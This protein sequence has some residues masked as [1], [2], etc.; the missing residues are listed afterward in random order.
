[1]NSLSAALAVILLTA[2]ATR[3]QVVVV[4]WNHTWAVMHPMGTLPNGPGGP[5][6]DFDATW[7]LK[8]ADFAAQYDGPA[9][10]AV[11]SQS[12]IATTLNS[13]DSRLAQGPIGYGAATYFTAAGAEFTAFGTGGTLTTPADGQKRAAYFRSTFTVPAG[14][15]ALIRP[16]IRYLLDDGAY[17]YLDGE[18]V[19]AIFM[20][21][22]TPPNADLYAGTPEVVAGGTG[23]STESALRSLNLDLAA[24]TANA[25]TGARTIKQILSLTE[26][27]H[28]LALSVRNP[29]GLTSSDIAMALE[30][31]GDAGCTLSATTANV[32]R[33]D[34]GTPFVPGDDTFT[35]SATVTGINAGAGWTSDDAAMASGAYDAPVTFGPYPVSGGA[36]VVNFTS[37]SGTPCTAQV[38]VP[39]PG[40]V[41]TATAQSF[42]RHPQGTLDPADDT[43]TTSVLVSGQFVSNGWRL[44]STTP[45][46]AAAGSPVSGTTGTVAV[47]GPYNTA[48]APVTVVLADAADPAI[49]TQIVLAPQ[50]YIGTRTFGGVT[51]NFLSAAPLPTQ[52]TATATIAPVM[53]HTNGGGDIWREFR[54]PVFDL[55][56]T[57]AVGFA[58]ELV[59]RETSTTSNFEI[60]DAFRAKLIVTD[61]AGT[62]EVN[63]IAPFDTD[64]NGMLNG[65]T[66]YDPAADEFNIKREAIAIAISNT[67]RLEAAIPAAATAVQL[68]VEGK[69]LGA[70][71]FFDARKI[72]FSDQCG[73][74]VA[75]SNLTRN[76]QG[77]LGNP[78]AHTVAFTL[79]ASPNGAVS[80]AGWD[81]SFNRLGAPVAGASVTSG[82]Y[83]TN[84]VITGLPAEG[85][86]IT[87][88]LK[89]KADASCLTG[90]NITPPA[91]PLLIG[92][93]NVGAATAPVYSNGTAT[94]WTNGANGTELTAATAI[95]DFSTLPVDLSAISGTVAFS[96]TLEAEETSTTSNFEDTDIF[97]A[98][99]LLFD[100]TITTTVNLIQARDTNTNGQM[101][102]FVTAGYIAASDEF[103][104]AAD[105]ITAA[106]KNT[107]ALA[108][109]I[110]D[111]IVTAT[112]HIRGRV[113][114]SEFLRM[115]NVRWVASGPTGPADT[116]G[117]GVSDADEIVAGTSPTD[118]AS[119]FRVASLT[120]AG[121]TV[122]AGFATVNGKF[123]HGYTSSNLT[124][125]SRDDSRAALTGDGNPAAWP[126]TP[127]PA[128]GVPARYFRV[129]VGASAAAFPATMP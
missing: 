125:W 52:W 11:P 80:T 29:T 92:T 17:L 28:T 41:L 3:A 113:D 116:D 102:G 118:A 74:T 57:G 72:S 59:A 96:M 37:V 30:L 75:V 78:A 70:D 90:L 77:Q 14:G 64:A 54:S 84:V 22:T 63:L 94:G 115:Q 8:A 12:G 6:A 38:S 101:N 9:F 58:M 44:V 76:I 46:A 35:F 62:V 5:D 120:A 69:N 85:A 16:R 1:M 107:F 50:N 25:T 103:N 97:L 117:D 126:F 4:P 127:V 71:E 89:D 111:N 18:L 34:A 47:F 55:T 48:N 56:N 109:T 68:V 49:T 66:P 108:H 82:A 61:A 114:A 81:V 123:Y 110:P 93:L 98:E 20:A 129:A 19:A 67:L 119:V 10:G 106:L 124:I 73:F 53:T 31:T 99:L 43:F 42:T 7:F 2:G 79:R 88:I 112:L 83:S 60:A 32:A 39:P 65:A 95:S 21:T 121:T 36:K 45:A 104:T 122:T 105:P 24:G 91:A 128:A 40:G 13:Y 86:P 51:T 23:T 33:S 15:G 26:G 87:A 100:G 27:A